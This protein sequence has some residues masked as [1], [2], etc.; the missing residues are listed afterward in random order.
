MAVDAEAAS[1]IL[2]GKTKR[3]LVA[4][5]R[6]IPMKILKWNK[7]MLKIVLLTN[8]SRHHHGTTHYFDNKH[9]PCSF[10][11]KPSRQWGQRN[12]WRELNEK[13][14]L[15]WLCGRGTKILLF[16]IFI[17]AIV[18][19][20]VNISKGHLCHYIKYIFCFKK[21]FFHL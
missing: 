15:C 5:I 13:C 2:E 21:T 18:L 19:K 10:G 9:L 20:K 16:A 7:Q 11:V 3:F 4:W 6:L 12:C 14:W 1:W 8:S 17:H